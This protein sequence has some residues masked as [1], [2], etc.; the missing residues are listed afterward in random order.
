MM[1]ASRSRNGACKVQFLELHVVNNLFMVLPV[2]AHLKAEPSSASSHALR[3]LCCVV[4]YFIKPQVGLLVP[5]LV[6]SIQGQLLHQ[7]RQRFCCMHLHE[8]EVDAMPVV[9]DYNYLFSA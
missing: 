3:L 4:A 1:S 7:P 9:G 5:K 8:P 6:G 2:H